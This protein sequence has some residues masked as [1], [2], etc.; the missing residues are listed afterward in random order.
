MPGIVAGALIAHP[1]VLVPEVGGLSAE[2]VGRTAAAMRRL[3][4]MLSGTDGDLLIV[5]SPHG[6]GGMF[7]LPVRR[8]PE[9]SGDL[10]RFRAPHVKVAASVDVDGS[11]R[12]VTAAGQAGF[13]LRWSGDN[14][15]DHGV[16]VPLHVLPRTSA[17]R[18]VIVLGISGWPL[19]QFHRFG[20]WLHGQI[21]DRNAI[22]LASG[23]LSHRLTRD[24]PYGFQ[25]EGAVFDNLVIE[26]LHTQDWESIGRVAPALAEEAGECGLRPLALLLGAARAA[27]LRSEVLSYEGPFGVGYPVVHFGKNGGVSDIQA[28]GRRAIETYLSEGRVIDPPEP[29]APELQQPSAAF[30]TLRKAG[31]LRGCMGSI[32]PTRPSA[33]AEIIRYAI[34]SA[35]RDP[36][37]DP[38]T[39]SEVDHLTV[40]VQLLDP[41]E[42][43][44]SLADLDPT[45]YG[46]IARRGD[47]QALLLPGID[48]IGSVVEQLAAVCQ[49]AGIDPGGPLTLERF[50]TR[51]IS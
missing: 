43:V 11:A 9:V 26:A 37:F 36:R 29:V 38:V 41:P 33:A 18:L 16:V 24:A 3:D 39:L 46:L 10:G 45:V 34:A 42:P 13:R 17:G 35:V 51:T 4:D 19:E 28:L 30:V 2:R 47:R 12:L 15:L 48:G 27:G 22:L 23:D 50:R 6:P 49:K 32:V 14:N 20:A 31:E 21:L 7:E 25:K 8:G 44:A 40:S 5:V 1:P